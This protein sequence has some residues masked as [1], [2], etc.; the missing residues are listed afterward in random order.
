MGFR[1]FPRIGR[2]RG[3]ISIDSAAGERSVVW[4]KATC[5]EYRLY[6]QVDRSE[7]SMSALAICRESRRANDADPVSR[8]LTGKW[9]CCLQ[10]GAAET[11]SVKLV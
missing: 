1:K 9:S 6:G 2:C 11:R 5:P 10:L 3:E 8:D 4:R 7:C